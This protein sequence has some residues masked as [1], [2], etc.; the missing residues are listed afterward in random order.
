M[1]VMLISILLALIVMLGGCNRLTYRTDDTYQGMGGELCEESLLLFLRQLYSEE[2]WQKLSD[3][4]DD[5]EN[6]LSRFVTYL[7]DNDMLESFSGVH[8]TFRDIDNDPHHGGWLVVMNWATRSSTHKLVIENN[9]ELYGLVR[10]IYE[11][12]VIDGIR[13]RVCSES[14]QIHFS[15]NL[16]S[17]PFTAKFY[18]GPNYFLYIT[19]VD[20]PEQLEYRR[21]RD[22]WFM[23]IQLPHDA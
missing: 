10:D 12:G 9:P 21:L 23:M 11:R 8:I 22:K 1:K 14:T 3:L 20:I 17:R 2:N 4:F 18:N 16:E 7:E 19:N 6:E 13:M 15:I 5:V